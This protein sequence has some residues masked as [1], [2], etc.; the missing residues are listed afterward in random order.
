MG[1]YFYYTIG[2]AY[3]S[4]NGRDML[5]IENYA[6]KVISQL[7]PIVL[8]LLPHYLTLAI[9]NGWNAIC[10]IYSSLNLLFSNNFQNK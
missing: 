4:S 3:T 5:K 6:T 2:R 9:K 1:L 10:R 8:F 7:S